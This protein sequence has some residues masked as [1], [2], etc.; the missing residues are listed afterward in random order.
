[1]LELDLEIMF[2]WLEHKSIPVYIQ[3]V[4]KLRQEIY[5]WRGLL[6]LKTDKVRTDLKY[7]CVSGLGVKLWNWLNDDIK[8]SKSMLVV[9]KTLKCKIIRG[10]NEC[11]LNLVFQFKL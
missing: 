11:W 2:E 9:K 6:K 1:M 8:M 7:R 4:F 5:N 10:Y 3:K